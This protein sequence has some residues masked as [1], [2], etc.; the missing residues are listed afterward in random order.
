MRDEAATSVSG[1]FRLFAEAGLIAALLLV[2]VILPRRLWC[3]PLTAWLLLCALQLGLGCASFCILQF[4]GDIGSSVRSSITSPQSLALTALS[5]IKRLQ[6]FAGDHFSYHC[7]GFSAWGYVSVFA[8]VS[9]ALCRARLSTVGAAASSL[10]VTLALYRSP[11]Y[12][13]A[14]TYAN[15]FGWN[16]YFRGSWNGIHF[17]GERFFA[18]DWHEEKLPERCSEGG[19]WIARSHMR[20]VCW[21]HVHMCW[22]RLDFWPWETEPRMPSEEDMTALRAKR[23]ELKQGRELRKSQKT[24]S[25]TTPSTLDPKIIQDI[26]ARAMD[27]LGGEEGVAMQMDASGKDAVMAHYSTAAATILGDT[28]RQTPTAAELDD[29]HRAGKQHLGVLYGRHRR[30][31][32]Q[33]SKAA[34]KD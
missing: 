19:S 32:S 21:P 22:R 34:K 3:C 12:P 4:A 30:E 23:T 31:Q 33:R 26:L 6:G 1:F 27:S 18:V 28:T 29:L 17:E 10:V 13:L 9:L 2:A 8:S 14:L 5:A 15:G 25:K 16:V 7:M 24:E 20:T 11:W